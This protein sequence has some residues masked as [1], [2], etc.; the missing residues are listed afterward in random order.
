M[1]VVHDGPWSQTR[2]VTRQTDLID[3]C[4]LINLIKIITSLLHLCI[5]SPNTIGSIQDLYQSDYAYNDFK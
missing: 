5:N 4:I 3:I 2:S 1:Q